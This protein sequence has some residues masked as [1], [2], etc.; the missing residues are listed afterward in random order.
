MIA[1]MTDTVVEP[2]FVNNVPEI[3]EKP[4]TEPNF[5]IGI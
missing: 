2:I 4:A 3:S 1:T 5:E